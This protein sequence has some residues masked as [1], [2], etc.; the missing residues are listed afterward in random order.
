MSEPPAAAQSAGSKTEPRKSKSQDPGGTK[1]ATL[2]AAS[3]RS[4]KADNVKAAARVSKLEPPRD[5]NRL[6]QNSARLLH[7]FG[8]EVWC[9]PRAEFLVNIASSRCQRTFS[10]TVRWH[11]QLCFWSAAQ[12]QMSVCRRAEGTT[13][14]ISRIMCCYTPLETPSTS[15]T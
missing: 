5:A 1:R 8:L 6:P 9:T 7:S 3:S 13:Y 12:D 2:K 14:A 10:L 15:I 11:L 4:S